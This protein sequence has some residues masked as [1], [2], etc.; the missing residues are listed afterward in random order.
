MLEASARKADV[1][2]IASRFEHAQKRSCATSLPSSPGSAVTCARLS[3]R[4]T[5]TVTPMP[6]DLTLASGGPICPPAKVSAPASS[7]RRS[8]PG[9]SGALSRRPT[10]A[11]G[12]PPSGTMSSTRSYSRHSRRFHV[13]S[14][15]PWCT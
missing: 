14:T 9:R 4:I 3:G 6:L 12:S 8:P 10:P 13:I 5:S 1:N 7:T 11:A 15:S 2:C